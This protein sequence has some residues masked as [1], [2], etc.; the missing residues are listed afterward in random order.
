MVADSRLRGAQFL[1][2][3]PA[4]G[5]LYRR[6]GQALRLKEPRLGVAVATARE[7]LALPEELAPLLY[8]EG[9]RPALD[10]FVASYDRGGA[11]CSL[12]HF[13]S[14]WPSWPRSGLRPLLAAKK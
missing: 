9:V 1:H 2:R 10:V 5:E 4:K 13:T 3:L 8:D 11:K 7:T 12:S 6:I 14:T